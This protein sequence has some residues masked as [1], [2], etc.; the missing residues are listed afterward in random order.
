MALSERTEKLANTPAMRRILAF[1]DGNIFPA[2]YAAAVLLSAFFGLELPLFCLTALLVAFLCAF[3][4]D[5]RAVLVPVVLVMFGMSWKHTPQPPY[6]SGFFNGIPALVTLGAAGAVAVSALVWRMAARPCEHNLF[7][8]KSAFKWSLFALAAAF[9]LNGAFFSGYKAADLLLGAL[10]ALSFC[11]LYIFFFNTLQKREGLGRYAA[12]LLVLASAVIAVQLFKILLADGVV[13]EGSIDKDL[14]IAGWGMSN[15]I[16]GYLAA[17]LPA[18]FYL[19]LKCRRGFL[20]YV[21]G[22]FFYGCVFLTLSR[23]SVLVGG[24]AVVACAVYMSVVKSP[25]RTFARIFNAVCVLA[26]A[27]CAFLLRDRIRDLF[28]VFFERGFG[29]SGRF[30]I[31]K[32]GLVNFL[33]APVF[34]VGFYEPIA[35]DWSYEVANWVFPDLYHNLF[36]QMLAACG[37]VGLA[38]LL[39]HLAALAR[40]AFAKGMTT[41]KLFYLAIV[42]MILAASLLDNHIFH[43]FH[44][45]VYSAFLLFAERETRAKGA[46]AASRAKAGAGGGDAVSGALPEGGEGEKGAEK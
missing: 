26:A 17:F 2:V 24:V 21:L 25:C 22:F 20:F 33:R 8:E 34:G 40:L 23:A 4:A 43:I 35:P 44:A 1:F 10:F 31:W 29:D 13:R 39:F 27:V 11:A 45:L 36:I 18:S 6:D 16:G 38:A 5:T 14:L 46:P 28:A 41:E 32:Q 3:A 12:Y 15:N 37:A 7:K 19:A 30:F 42:C 9:L